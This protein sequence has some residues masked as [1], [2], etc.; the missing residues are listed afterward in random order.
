[1]L[2]RYLSKEKFEWLLSDYGLYIGSAA[3]QSDPKEG[4]YDS[5]TITKAVKHRMGD[6]NQD[7][8]SRLD[9]LNENLMQLNRKDNY[10]S[11]WYA[12]VT[13]TA[14]M[15]NEYGSDGV[16]LISDELL[17]IRLLPEPITNASSFYEI[18]YSDQKKSIAINEPLKFKEEKYRHEKEFRLVVDMN[19]YSKLT[20]FDREQFGTVY[21]DGKPS[22]E[23]DL[24]TCCMS[25]QGKQQSHCVIKAKGDGYVIAYDLNR[26]IKQIRLHPS[27]SKDDF[28]KV[29][30]LLKQAQL[31]VTVQVSTLRTIES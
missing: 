3:G 25:E 2:I 27:A 19:R 31:D 29:K 28:L 18:A 9:D 1:M 14:E 4:L 15:W 11:S 21:A 7:L 5:S 23:N 13:E 20:G 17:L 16:A 26:I 30:E 12:G 10:L 8:F 22:Y 6:I 24:F